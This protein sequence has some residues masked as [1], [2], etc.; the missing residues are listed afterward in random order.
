MRQ[1][2]FL[3][4]NINNNPVHFW[5]PFAKW[6]LSITNIYDAFT[7]PP[8]NISMNYQYPILLTGLGYTLFR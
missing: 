5:C 8:E 3:V 6:A 1:D 2:H 4:Y 7:M